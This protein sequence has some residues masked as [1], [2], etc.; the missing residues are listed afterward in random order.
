MISQLI[1]ELARASTLFYENV[2]LFQKSSQLYKSHLDKDLRKRFCVGEH[3]KTVFMI[4]VLIDNKW[5]GSTAKTFYVEEEA[6]KE[7]ARL[8]DEY[9]GIFKLRIVSRKEKE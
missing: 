3:C 5:E 9:A 2:W 6:Q 8:E 4:E 1:N 7:L